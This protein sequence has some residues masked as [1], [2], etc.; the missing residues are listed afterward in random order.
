MK[1]KWAQSASL[2]PLHRSPLSLHRVST[3]PAGTLWQKQSSRATPHHISP[4]P[5]QEQVD[6]SVR[7]NHLEVENGRPN[8]DRQGVVELVLHDP[9]NDHNDAE[10]Q[11]SPFSTAYKEKQSEKE[12]KQ[13]IRVPLRDHH[14]AISPFSHSHSLT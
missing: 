8:N 13:K 11:S 6:N 1:Q 7:E 12:E 9:Q 14:Y 2:W 10:L 3:T 4:N 5:N